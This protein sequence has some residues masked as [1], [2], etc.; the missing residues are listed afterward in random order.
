MAKTADL[1]ESEKITPTQERDFDFMMD[2]ANIVVP[3]DRK[4]GTIG[5]YRDLMRAAALVHRHRPPSRWSSQIFRVETISR[6]KGR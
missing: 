3:P 5:V 1:A 2:H 4:Q 6:I